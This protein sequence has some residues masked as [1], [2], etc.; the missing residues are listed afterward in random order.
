LIDHLVYATPDLAATVE[1]LGRRLGLTPKPG[2]QHAGIGT[3]NFLAALGDG[4]YLE[5]IGP[6]PEQPEPEWPRPFGIDQLTEA[7][8]VTWAARVTDLAEVVEQAR[9][10]GHDPGPVVPLSR[11]RPDGVLLEWQLTFPTSDADGGLVPFLIDWG[12][13]P[14]PSETA[15]PGLRL[16]SFAGVHPDPALVQ[17]K[18]AALGQR[19]PVAEGAA[20]ALRAVVEAPAGEVVLR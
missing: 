16:R 6:D 13:S 17:A 15:A 11:T 7:R 5:V 10:A 18:L 19:L 3:R 4:A 2:G 14:H 12:D 20:P 8:L 9:A 1:Q